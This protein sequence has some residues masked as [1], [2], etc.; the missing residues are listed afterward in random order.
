[1]NRFVLG[2]VLMALMVTGCGEAGPELVAV[3]GTANLAGGKPLDNVYLEFWPENNGP[4]SV[5]LTDAQGKFVL[6]TVDGLTTGAIL[7]KHRVVVL[8]KSIVKTAFLGRAGEDVDMTGGQK[9]RTGELYTSP[10]QTPL[11]VTIEGE[12][13]DLVLEIEPYKVKK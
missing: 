2:S 3:E 1:M 4:K 9:P 7:G 10:T 11:A 6:K 5:A 12:K 13:K 8:D